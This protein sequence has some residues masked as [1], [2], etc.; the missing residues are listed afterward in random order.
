MRYTGREFGVGIPGRN[1]V[2]TER[3]RRWNIQGLFDGTNILILF[4]FTEN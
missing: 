2:Y 3:E 4:G 1:G